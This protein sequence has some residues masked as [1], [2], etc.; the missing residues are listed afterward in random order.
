MHRLCRVLVDLGYCERN[1]S[2][3]NCGL[4][5][6]GGT[7]PSLTGNRPSD[8]LGTSS[9]P[10]ITAQHRLK[11]V[12]LAKSGPDF[13][14]CM[15]CGG[16][17]SEEMLHAGLV[18]GVFLFAGASA[19][20]DDAT[21]LGCHKAVRQAAAGRFSHGAVG[22][23][24]CHTEHGPNPGKTAGDHLL[25][26]KPPGLCAGCHDKVMNKEFSHEP[27]KS[28]C[29]ICHNPHAGTAADLRADSNAICLE[30]HSTAN[31]SK[32]ETDSPVKLF[33]GQVTLPA[34][35]FQNLRLLELRSDR[36]HP[37]SN[38]P[39]NRPADA[40]SP[41]VRCT[42]CHDAHSANNSAA[43]LVTETETAA[44]LCQRCHQ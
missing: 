5:F 24:S 42:T 36:G 8:S 39:V 13:S 19:W 11:P 26:S 44:P 12:P 34:R 33:G 31:R 30:C 15:A 43:F 4:Y 25:I 27:T 14:L 18:L 10:K 32:F 16:L 2:T 28:D 41:A 21:C 20:A 9:L 38:H 35:P 6:A 29:T 17:Q 37:V 1:F 40:N 7:D 3:R 22:C 23:A